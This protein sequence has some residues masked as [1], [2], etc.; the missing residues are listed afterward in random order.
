MSFQTSLSFE[1]EEGDGIFLLQIKIKKEKLSGN[2]VDAVICNFN[3]S[4]KNYRWLYVP[5]SV[6]G[7]KK[8][9]TTSEN[10]SALI[11]LGSYYLNKI[12]S[13]F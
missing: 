4:E 8:I 12:K 6:A 5:G 10:I 7:A 3:H 2:N 1:L 11:L 13:Y 9:Q